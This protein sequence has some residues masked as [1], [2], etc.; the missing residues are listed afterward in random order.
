MVNA[1]S[2][3]KPAAKGICI[4]VNPVKSVSWKRTAALMVCA[5]LMTA[6]LAACGEAEFKT[7]PYDPGDQFITNV[8]GQ[9]RLMLVSTVMID[10]ANSKYLDQLDDKNYVVRTIITQFMTEQDYA[11]LSA[12]NAMATLSAE[13]ALELNRGLGYDYVY[14]VYLQFYTHG[15]VDP[16][17]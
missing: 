1:M 8:S 9:S 17:R 15:T 6:L 14:K 13:L 7:F 4:E 3:G 16:S 11:T 12:S 2:V 10:V 5:V